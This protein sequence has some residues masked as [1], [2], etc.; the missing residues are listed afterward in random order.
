MLC[1]LSSTGDHGRSSAA[2]DPFH[3]T[4]RRS[5]TLPRW[6]LSDG[7]CGR[8]VNYSDRTITIE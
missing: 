1:R 8:R 2:S 4:C 3:K 6:T 5:F 7:S